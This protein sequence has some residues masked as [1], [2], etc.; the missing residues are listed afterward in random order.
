[1]IVGIYV[2]H[3]FIIIKSEIVMTSKGKHHI[4]KVWVDH[5]PFVLSF[6]R[7]IKVCN[8]S[9]YSPSWYY[10]GH[11]LYI[12]MLELGCDALTLFAKLIFRAEIPL[13]LKNK[14]RLSRHQNCWSFRCSLSIAYRRCFNYIFIPDSTHVFNEFDDENCKTIWETCKS[15]F[16]CD[17]Y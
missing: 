9:K 17:L 4:D 12:A 13:N 10:P 3:I 1:M 11:P 5:T 8:H 7:T 6:R 15:G 2:L 14:A 16:W